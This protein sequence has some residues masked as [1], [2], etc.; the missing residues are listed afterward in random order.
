MYDN[1][2]YIR[3]SADSAL[4]TDIA[5]AINGQYSAAACYEQL[6]KMAPH[7][8]ERNQILE[9]RKDEI[10]HFQVFS[11]IYT[12]LSGRQPTPQLGEQCPSDY[13]TGLNFAFKDEQE[14]VDFYL[15]IAEK[16]NHP[17]IKEQFRR[18]SAD[19]Q[20]HAVW[21]L[22]FLTQRKLK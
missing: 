10:R 15:D 2:Y 20:N 5:K 9:I 22:Y 17:F 21:F 14:T 11:Q 3:S 13:Y 12:S 16:W 19:E 6:A 8:E 1:H 4:I 7:E 18:A